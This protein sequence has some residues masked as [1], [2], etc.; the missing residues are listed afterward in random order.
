[1]CLYITLHYPRRLRLAALSKQS[2]RDPE[3]NRNRPGEE[4]ALKHGV[5]S[6]GPGVQPVT[7]L[8]S[9]QCVFSCTDTNMLQ[10]IQFRFLVS[11]SESERRNQVLTVR[12]VPLVP[13]PVCVC[14]HSTA[15]NPVFVWRIPSMP[16][17]LTGHWCREGSCSL[18]D[19]H[20]ELRLIIQ[21]FYLN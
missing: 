6:S 8:I 14:S 15:C 4:P 3:Q 9:P 21:T 20:S 19:D 12:A 16:L 13:S 11:Y 7:A 5:C 17:T 1:M 2:R 10:Q 18:R